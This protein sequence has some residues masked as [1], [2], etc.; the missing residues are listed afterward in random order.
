MAVTFTASN[1]VR[2]VFGTEYVVHAKIDATG[3]TTDNGDTLNPATVGL[4]AFTCA[5]IIHSATVDDDSTVAGGWVPAVANP[6]GQTYK[7]VFYS[8]AVAGAT[9]TLKEITP[10][11]SVGTHAYFHVTCFGKN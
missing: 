7:I 5:P 2:Q 11:T 10:G 1:V 3:T 4:V 9:T 6:T 8:Q